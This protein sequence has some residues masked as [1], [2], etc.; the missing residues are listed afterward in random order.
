[1][2]WA[3]T[4]R[5]RDALEAGDLATV[6]AEL[7]RL[8]RLA[9]DSRRTYFRWCLLVLQAARALFAGRLAEGERL[10]AEAVELNRRHGDDADQEYT[11]Q[12][13][14]LAL[15]R[16]RPQDAPVA[17]LRDYAARYPALPVWE[18]M[19]AR[20]EHARGSDAAPRS[21]E[22]CARDGFAAVLRTPDWLCAL[23]LLAE[24]VAALG[25]PGAGRAAHRRARPARRPQ[26]GD[27]R[28]LGGVRAGRAP[29]RRARGRRRPARRGGRAASSGRRR[30]PPA[31]TRRAG[32][33]PR[34]PTCC[35][36]RR[37]AGDPVR[38]RA[39]ALARTLELPGLATEI[40]AVSG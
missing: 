5:L 28:R 3:R 17:E 13:L 30:S 20:A 11:V 26:R 31:G 33:S 25:D 14:A 4:M 18:A 8:A 15:L 7:D 2:F 24:P 38:E 12:R 34:S 39:L 6:D 23:A 32:S 22:A 36:S 16:R 1:M 27:G 19:R 29:A 10:A 40:G 21:V 35:A 37:S 9:A